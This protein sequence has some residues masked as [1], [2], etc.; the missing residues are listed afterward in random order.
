MQEEDLRNLEQKK[1]TV[2]FKNIDNC[3]QEYYSI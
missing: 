1:K 3:K 2:G